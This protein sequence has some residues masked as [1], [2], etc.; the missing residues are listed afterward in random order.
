MLSRKEAVALDLLVAGHKY[1]LELVKASEGVLKRGTVYVL[2]DVMEDRGYVI[3]EPDQASAMS[4]TPRR[5]Y[6][7]TGVGERALNTYQLAKLHE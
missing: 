2:L 6:R 3:S 7:S 5:W 1:G 4:V